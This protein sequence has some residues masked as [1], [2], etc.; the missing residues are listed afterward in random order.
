[1]NRYSRTFFASKV[2]VAL[3]I[4]GVFFYSLSLPKNLSPG[5]TPLT[6]S[7]GVC[8]YLLLSLPSMLAHLLWSLPSVCAYLLVCRGSG[9]GGYFFR[10]RQKDAKS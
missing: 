10:L 9:A 6:R 8:A 7:R 2:Q 3:I 5:A 1:M 4:E